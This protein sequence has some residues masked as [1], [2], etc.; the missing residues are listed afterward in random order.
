MSLLEAAFLITMRNQNSNYQ[1][2]PIIRM[3]LF[4]IGLNKYTDVKQ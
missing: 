3:V 2:H 4:D 1:N